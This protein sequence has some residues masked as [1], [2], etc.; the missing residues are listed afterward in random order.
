MNF[1]WCSGHSS[2]ISCGARLPPVCVLQVLWKREDLG[3]TE[4]R[5]LASL[6]EEEAR[7]AI[8]GERGRDGR[9]G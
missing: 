6:S 8:Q 3:E 2:W 4:L 5:A 1:V 7:D 9:G